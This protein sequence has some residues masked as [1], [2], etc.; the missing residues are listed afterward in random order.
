MGARRRVLLRLWDRPAQRH[1]LLELVHHVRVAPHD[2]AR[3][4]IFVRQLVRW[5]QRWVEGARVAEILCT[6]LYMVDDTTDHEG[7]L[8]DRWPSH[9][10]ITLVMYDDPRPSKRARSRA[11]NAR[12]ILTH[13]L[14]RQMGGHNLARV[15]AEG[16]PQE[17]GARIAFCG[18][19]V[20]AGA[21]VVY[22]RIRVEEMGGGSE[23]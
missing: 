3:V 8:K 23:M 14:R 20:C 16:T 10:L 5:A 6:G 12:G 13:T 17:S 15:R 11:C 4:P 1:R 21:E 7:T 9:V 18:A 19:A 2:Q 22:S